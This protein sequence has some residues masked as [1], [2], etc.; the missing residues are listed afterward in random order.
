MKVATIKAIVISTFV[1][2]EMTSASANPNPHGGYAVPRHLRSH[3]GARTFNTQTIPQLTY[4]H[5]GYLSPQGAKRIREFVNRLHITDDQVILFR[6]QKEKIPPVAKSYRPE[7]WQNVLENALT[8]VDAHTQRHIETLKARTETARA[9]GVADAHERR[10]QF[11]RD[12]GSLDR[13]VVAHQESYGLPILVS[14]TRSLAVAAGNYMMRNAVNNNRFIYILTPYKKSCINV[15]AADQFKQRWFSLTSSETKA[16]H[17][18]AIWLTAQ[19]C[20]AGI[21]D[22]FTDSFVEATSPRS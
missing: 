17:E 8:H 19:Q 9:C 10:L 5:F 15:H 13:V 11:Y 16:E 18:I 4:D 14:A 22:T 7:S 2:I 21:Y 3:W 20:V 12:A 1:M 6:G